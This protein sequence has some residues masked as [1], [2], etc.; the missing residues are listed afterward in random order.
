MIVDAIHGRRAAEAE[1]AMREH[2]VAILKWLNG[3]DAS[4]PSAK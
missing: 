2:L 1:Q 3:G 4:A